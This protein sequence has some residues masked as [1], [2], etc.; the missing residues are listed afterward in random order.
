MERPRHLIR[1]T[2]A[3]VAAAVV[4]VGFAPAAA[5]TEPAYDVIAT[6]LD[7]PRHLQ[8]GADG[9]LYV[10]EAGRGGDLACAAGPEGGTVCSGLSGAITAITG[11]GQGR[12]VTGLPSSAAPETG[13]EAIGPSDVAETDAG[14]LV[15][16]GLG[17][18]PATRAGLPVEL[19]DVGWLLLA[20]PDAGTV[21]RLADIA[22]FEGEV[23]PDG[24]LPDSNPNAVLAGDGVAVVVDAGGNS[25]LAVTDEGIDVLATFPAR[26]QTVTVQIPDGP[27]LGSQ[28]PTDSVPTSVAAA[29]DA[30]V[31]GELTG[32]PFAPGGAQ[33]YRVAD[34][35]SVQATGFTNIVD[36][37]VDD[38]GTVYVV[39]LAQDGL[40]S[41]PPGAA[42][43]GRLVRVGNDGGPAETVAEL[44]A[45]GGVAISDGIAYVTTNS[46][47]A[48]AGQVVAVPLH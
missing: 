2:V 29:H 31:V 24:G 35:V 25:L 41:V 46:T 23:N 17:A 19:Q 38:N 22:G 3:G 6:G 11:D 7:N 48:G 10:A 39:E 26:P 13:G 16:V 36:V 21:E 33:V 30:L 34:E 4:A 47:S 18:D 5:A 27:P 42:P 44:P 9:T 45:P 8:F 12:V 40:L 37:E 28:I 20:D 15:T 43:V 32:F 14:L 1:S